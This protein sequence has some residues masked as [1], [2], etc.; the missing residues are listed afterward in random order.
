MNGLLADTFFCIGVGGGGGLVLSV[1]SLGVGEDGKGSGSPHYKAT[2]MSET[3][4]E[5][6]LVG[7]RNDP[8][9]EGA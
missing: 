3:P 8:R 2:I 6:V 9:F 1:L 4:R 7:G 5:G